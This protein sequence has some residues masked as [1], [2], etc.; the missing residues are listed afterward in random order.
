M[1]IQNQFGQLGYGQAMDVGSEG[2]PH[3]TLQARAAVNP[4][5]AQANTFTV[6]GTASDGVYTIQVVDD[7]TGTVYAAS[8]TRGS[9]ETNAQIAAALLAEI[10]DVANAPSWANLAAVSNS[11]GGVLAIAFLHTEKTYT[12]SGTAPG[13]GT[14]TVAETQAAGGTSIPFGRFLVFVDGSEDG[15][16]LPAA[17][18]PGD[19]RG[20]SVRAIGHFV[21]QGSPLA[22][23]NDVIPPG[24]TY[25][26][27]F[28]GKIRV[29]NVGAS[30]VRGGSVF[31]V[32]NVAGG[33]ELGAARGD[34]DGANSVELDSR[35][36]YWA[37]PVASGEIG[38]VELNL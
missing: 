3:A 36:A 18:D 24:N 1:S 11:G 2:E 9:S 4:E 35:A 5:L 30:A 38:Y 14:V 26:A 34:D 17:A 37:E 10:E 27:G 7:Q 16:A 20:V 12:V 33:D 28:R 29:K 21:N 8:F 15:M 32:V 6:G 31:V 13:T 22:A 23:A 25:S 19:I